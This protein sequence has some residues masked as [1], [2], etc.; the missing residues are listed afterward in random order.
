MHG[1][2]D[3]PGPR[4]VEIGRSEPDT[5][6]GSSDDIVEQRPGSPLDRF[7]RGRLAGVALAAVLAAGIGIG[8]L[9]GR[10]MAADTNPP[11]TVVE[12]VTVTATA[13]PSS[14]PYDQIVM[15]GATCT[16]PVGARGLQLGFEITNGLRVPVT[17][18]GVHG[19]FGPDGLRQTASRRGPCAQ[20]PGPPD[21]ISNYQ[22]RP[23]ESVWI[24]VSVQLPRHCP[25][26]FPP[27]I[28]VGYLES[29]HA[30]TIYLSPFPDLPGQ[31]DSGC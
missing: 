23:A 30:T 22:L 11:S 21:D 2:P 8:Y 9:A 13:T 19:D 1:P 14:T 4:F 6:P 5:G 3:E 31:A 16:T 20:A 12:Q 10:H 27:R 24:T 7:G 18:T 17:L 26:F 29:G 15:T 28:G 25:V